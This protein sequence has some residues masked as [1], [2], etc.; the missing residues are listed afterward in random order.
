LEFEA[1]REYT[2]KLGLRNFTEWRNYTNNGSKEFGSK[3]ENI[4]AN[5]QRTYGS[6]GSKE[7]K[8]WGDFLGTGRIATD[9]R[10]YRSFEESK[11]YV[12]T[13]GL[14][15]EKG[16]RGTDVSLCWRDYIN[17]KLRNEIGVL[18]D[19]I[20]NNPSQVYGNEWTN[21]PDWL[22]TGNKPR[23]IE[24]VSY[25]EARKF[26]CKLGLLDRNIV[27]TAGKRKNAARQKWNDYCKGLYKDLPPKPQVIPASIHHTYK[28]SGYKGY[29]AFLTPAQEPIIK[30]S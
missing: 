9:R 23:N 14:K 27:R 26:A 17:G 22:G 5:P 29:L 21:W 16:G 3:P 4:P 10:Y 19:D 15:S 6:F 12:R 8:G 25:D 11:E 28:N 24:F 20:P 18:P 30:D 1:S 7:W 2:Q 13:L